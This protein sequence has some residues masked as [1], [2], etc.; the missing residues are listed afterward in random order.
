M[1]NK[2]FIVYKVIKMG[3][4]PYSKNTPS[5][6]KN[7]DIEDKIKE[8]QNR[9]NQEEHNL[10]LIQISSSKYPQSTSYQNKDS[11]I[12]ILKPMPK[13]SELSQKFDSIE[14]DKKIIRSSS[15]NKFENENNKL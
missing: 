14:S 11:N 2:L 10:N 5:I 7:E 1:Y 9:D 3:C 15:S 13:Q 6:P 8:K 12:I 4:I